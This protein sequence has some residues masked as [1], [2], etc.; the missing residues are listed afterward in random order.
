MVLCELQAG[1]H[2]FKLGGRFDAFNRIGLASLCGLPSRPVQARAP[3]H[4][5]KP[6]GWGKVVVGHL[7]LA[8]GSDRLGVSDPRTD[9]ASSLGIALY[10]WLAVRVGLASMPS[11]VTWRH[12]MSAGCL[13]G[14]GFTM[15]FFIACLAFENP[16][17]TDQAKM[18]VL[19]ASTIAG[20]IG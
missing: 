18:G 2:P 16:A 4:G 12:L 3:H 13:G 11:G 10:S 8:L 20:L 14:F 1:K 9:Y 5:W 17:Y 19:V 6:D 15:S 7:Q